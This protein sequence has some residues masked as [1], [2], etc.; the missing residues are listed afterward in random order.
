MVPVSSCNAAFTEAKIGQFGELMNTPR[1]TIGL[2]VYN[3][4]DFLQS[5]L[6]AIL[7]QTYTDFE[8][9]ISDNASTDGTE[10][11]CTAVA[12]RDGRVRYVRN[13]TNIGAAP[14]YNRLVELARGE[15]FRWNAHDDPVAPTHLERSV[16]ALRSHPDAA[17][18]YA[19]TILIDEADRVL[20]YHDD[21]Y[22]LGAEQPHERFR[23]FFGLSLWCHPVFGLMRTELVRRTGRIGSYISSDR[24]LLGE[25][26]L[27]GKTV[28]IPEYLAYRRL[29]PNISVWASKGPE[30]MLKWFDPNARLRFS[31]GRR[32]LFVEYVRAIER[33]GYG[34]RERLACYR[35]LLRYYVQTNSKVKRFTARYRQPRNHPAGA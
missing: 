3:G 28:E 11:I 21:R 18:V 29:H 32:K 16:A 13:A 4:E 7:N 23:Q 15:Y 27:L 22:R 35:A 10:A 5:T 9:I 20:E 1:V 33:T 2:P 17:V 19:R 24:V 26:A 31:Y 8:L 34:V 14:N 12:A 6:N 25:L 30:D